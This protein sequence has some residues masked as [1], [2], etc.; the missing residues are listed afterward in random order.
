MPFGRVVNEDEG[1][2]CP[3]VVNIESAG[4]ITQASPDSRMKAP[5]NPNKPT[6]Y[7]G[8]IAPTPSGWLHLGHAVTFTRAWQRARSAKGVIVYR[9]EDLDRDRCRPEFSTGAM[10]DLR[11]WG[12]DWD[13]GPDC[14][15]PWNPY[16]Q[17]ERMPLFEQAFSQ[18][19]KTGRVYP[20]PHSRQEIA[21]AGPERSPVDGDPLFPTRLR[22]APDSGPVTPPIEGI[23]W[24]FRVPD[25]RAI[26]FTDN[27][28]GEK[29]YLAGQDFGDF[30]VWRR[31][32][33]P[34]YDFAVVVD[35]HTMAITEVVRGED[36]LVSTARQLL[37]YEAMGWEPP[38]WYHCQLVMDPAT[39]KRMS[40]THKSLG[41]RALRA[42][43][44]P[45]G[46][47]PEAYA[48]LKQSPGA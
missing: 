28:T 39:G 27:R 19:V 42:N 24:R 14:G 31:D 10:E 47:K 45:A 11:W 26:R 4:I 48:G 5:E 43:G 3:F 7:R 2:S 29:T 30:I 23:N 38:E 20:S 18:L 17:S 36:L 6:K 13:E 15:G 44:F 32:G 41:L 16:V 21:R 25:G 12:L 8:R 37:I 46:L 40:K 35:D 9:T 22:Q 34:S 1:H 33:M